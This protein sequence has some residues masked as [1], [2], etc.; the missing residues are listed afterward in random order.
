M[1]KV[2]TFLKC[3]TLAYKIFQFSLPIH[4][5]N[6]F[7]FSR[8]FL[9]SVPTRRVKMEANV[10][11]R[12]TS[13]IAYVERGYNGTLCEIDI[14]E[15]R[16]KNCDNKTTDLCASSP[17]KNNGTCEAGE[18]W[19][20]CKCAPG[21]DGLTCQIN[22]NECASQPC[23]EGATC[24]DGIG[25]FRCICPSSKR[26]KRCEICKYALAIITSLRLLLSSL[27]TAR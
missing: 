7:L 3:P 12:S 2:K 19:F 17:C 15:C 27:G 8:S 14:N 16:S 6:L 26:G 25:N 11:T 21:F 10:L 5:S 9:Q 22:I 1:L 24:I 4:H 20:L 23:A 18:T 13:F